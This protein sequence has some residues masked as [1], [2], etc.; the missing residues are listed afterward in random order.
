M[1]PTELVVLY[2]CEPEPSDRNLINLAVFL[3]VPVRGISLARTGGVQGSEVLQLI[4]QAGCAAVSAGTLHQCVSRSSLLHM[5]QSLGLEPTTN[6]FV[7]GF[8]QGKTD[9]ELV[10]DLSGGAFRSVGQLGRGAHPYSVSNRSRAFC[11]E[12]CGLTFG[13]ADLRNDLVF[14]RNRSEGKTADLIRAAGDTLLATVQN[15]ASFSVLSGAREILDIEATVA[16]GVR[17]L[18]WFSRLV[19]AMMFLRYA[20]GDRCW[21]P[22]KKLACF[23]LDDPLLRSRYGFLRYNSLL[24]AMERSNFATSLAFVPWNYNRSYRSTAEL[25]LRHPKRLSLSIHGCDHTEGEFGSVDEVL[26]S[27][28]AAIARRRMERHRELTGI[29]F[30]NVMVFPQGVF[31]S[32]ALKALK[33]TGYLAAVNSTPF[34]V[35]DSSDPLRVRDLLAPAITRY[36]G[37]PL[38]VRHYPDHVVDFALNLYLGKPALIVAHHDYFRNGYTSIQTFA[39]QLNCLSDGITWCRLEEIVRA[40]CLKKQR[41]DRTFD[42]QFYDNSILGVGTD[43]KES[44]PTENLRVPVASRSINGDS[45]LQLGSPAYRIGVSVRR[46]LCEFR[47]NYLSRSHAALAGLNVLKS[48]LRNLKR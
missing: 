1:Q 42:V 20:F 9:A 10:W 28:K 40:T 39:E 21:Q 15:G 17:P 34:S 18:D 5:V 22:G 47:D 4:R 11:Q 45:D 26:L 8:H 3:G 43:D 37:L 24:E 32:L 36:W 14:R 31:S 33:T 7:Y 29:P 44:L 48:Q 16:P 46:R 2:K 35:D 38:F 13:T 12:F 30:D 25:F 23:I 19:P 6:L 41:E 27:R